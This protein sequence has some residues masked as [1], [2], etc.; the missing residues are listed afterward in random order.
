MGVHAAQKIGVFWN[1]GKDPYFSG[2]GREFGDP[3]V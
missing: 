1:M 2:R 3:V